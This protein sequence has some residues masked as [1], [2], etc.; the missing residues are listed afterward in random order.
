MNISFVKAT[1]EHKDIILSWLD[2]P[3]IK[4]FW[5]NS[6]EH[7]DDIINFIEGRT[8]PSPYFN[9]TFDYWIGLIDKTPYC[10]ILTSEYADSPELSDI[11][12][13]QLSKT[14]KTFSIDFCIGHPDYL[15]KGLAAPTLQEFMRFFKRNVDSAVDRFFIDP[16]KNN[17]RAIHVYE[18]AGFRR[19]GE[20]IMEAGYFKGHKSILMIKDYES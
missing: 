7:R 17:P 19:V 20:F 14:G 16:D 8:T 2:A 18:K 1:R 12:S 3:H 10:F 11:H 4:A 6:Q 13:A 15:G 9:G 5:D